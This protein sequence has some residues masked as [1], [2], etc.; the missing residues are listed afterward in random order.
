MLSFTHA[1]YLIPATTSNVLLKQNKPSKCANN[2]HFLVSIFSLLLK[3]SE[4]VVVLNNLMYHKWL[5]WYLNVL[6]KCRQLL[7]WK[8]GQ[9]KDKHYCDISFPF[10]NVLSISYT[11]RFFA[12]WL[13]L[14]FQLSSLKN[15]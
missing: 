13:Y 11:L 2:D 7:L 3:V 1:D 15:R 6:I 14:V 5:D 9:L 12:L 8:E 4:T 10:G